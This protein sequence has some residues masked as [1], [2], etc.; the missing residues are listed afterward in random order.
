M[1]Q[2]PDRRLQRIPL[3]NE[4]HINVTRPLRGTQRLATVGRDRLQPTR[5]HRKPVQVSAN[6]RSHRELA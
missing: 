1:V 4:L 6:H 2:G 3:Q 5:Q